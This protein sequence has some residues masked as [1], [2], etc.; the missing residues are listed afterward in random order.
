MNFLEF[1]LR[2]FHCFF[3]YSHPLLSVKS[4][5]NNHNTFLNQPQH[6]IPHKP[7]NYFHREPTTKSLHNHD[8]SEYNQASITT[9][10]SHIHRLSYKPINAHLAF[11]T[12][13]I[14]NQIFKHANGL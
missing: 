9:I 1:C 10:T 12:Y 8:N 7:S 11:N 5:Q 6:V 14:Y 3:G 4:Y 13:N 2:F